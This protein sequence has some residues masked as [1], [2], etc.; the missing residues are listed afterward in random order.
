MPNLSVNYKQL[1]LLQIGNSTFTE[2]DQNTEAD[3]QLY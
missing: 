1:Y 2:A 3:W